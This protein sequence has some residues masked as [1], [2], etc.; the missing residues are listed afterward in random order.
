MSARKEPTLFKSLMGVKARAS[1]ETL[2]S[3]ALQ[4]F[5]QA[6]EKMSVAIATIN[7]DIA[8]DQAEVE[9]LTRRIG[10]SGKS[11]SHLERVS[12]RFKELLS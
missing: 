11:L 6:Q 1:H 9:E 4:G 8:D 2:A 10:E 12:L 3:E 5:L 7:K